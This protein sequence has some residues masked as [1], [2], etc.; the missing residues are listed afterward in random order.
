MM[1]NVPDTAC[2]RIRRIAVVVLLCI[3]LAPL[4]ELRWRLFGWP[5]AISRVRR[6]VLNKPRL[7]SFHTFPAELDRYFSANYGFRG[8]LIAAANSLRYYVFRNTV[9]SD[10]MIGRHGWLYYH[11]LSDG[12]IARDYYRNNLF[13]PAELANIAKRLTARRD[14]VRE[15]GAEFILLLAPDKGSVYPEHL[16]GD[17]GE[18]PRNRSAYMQLVE[19]LARRTDLHV[20]DT[21]TA[22]LRAKPHHDVPLLRVN[23][24]HWNEVGAF[25]AYRALALEMKE[26]FPQIRPARWSDYRV[27]LEPGMTRDLAE[28]LGVF[29]YN[30]PQEPR[31]QWTGRG[32]EP[33]RPPAWRLHRPQVL[34]QNEPAPDRIPKVLVFRDSFFTELARYCVRHCE[35]AHLIWARQLDIQRVADER[36]DLVI[37]Q[38]VERYIRFL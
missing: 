21:R 13:A 5:K 10:V 26:I 28:M 3:L 20:V 4:L 33:E 6:V 27:R 7:R 16:P 11:S 17:L 8:H 22:L 9:I 18:R 12:S 36:P 35:E 15:H 29:G 25:V 31:L 24:T 32:R 30:M 14:A 1:T 23:G 2:A 37:Q 38:S 34:V 19:Y